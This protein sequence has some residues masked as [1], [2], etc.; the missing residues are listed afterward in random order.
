[1]D[2][3]WLAAR[4]HLAPMVTKVRALL[5]LADELFEGGRSSGASV[6]YAAFE[7]QVAQ[8]TADLE[9]AVHETA[10]RGLD[11]DAPFVRVWG[12]T[13]RRVHRTERTYGTMAG[14]VVVERTLYRERGKR[15]G[16]VLDPVALR[17]GV[18]DGSWL[19]RTARAMSHLLAQG[20]SREASETCREL[21]RLPFSRSSFERVGHAVGAA[22]LARREQIEPQLIEA[23]VIP[24]GAH[25]IS[26]SIDRTTV[27]MEE[28][29]ETRPE[30][31]P[32]E[33][34]RLRE[35]VEALPP[36]AEPLD[37]RT[38]AL[39]R[40]QMRDVERSAKKVER[41]YRMAY[42]AT[43][44]LH[45]A[46]GEALHTIRYGR[47]PPEPGSIEAATHRQVHRLMERLR[48]DV[49]ALRKQ[50]ESLHVVLLADGAPEFW[51]LFAQY[52]NEATL[53]VTPIP[54]IDAWHALEY[55][56]AAARLLESR[57]KAWPGSF[58]RWKGWLLTETGGVERV[59]GA[60]RRAGLHNA[61]DASGARPVG[62]AI[63]YLEDRVARMHYASARATGLP[64]GSGAVEAT[65]KSLV[66]LRMKRPGS[67][68]KQA[69]GDE[70]LQLRALQLSDRW[71]PAITRTLASL[72]RPVHAL[73]R[74]E[75]L[76]SAA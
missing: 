11:I 64:I 7:E 36:S 69:S 23:L 47:M 55:V 20:T 1:M 46:R 29:V 70:V 8:S 59:L 24:E 27:P 35:A 37:R 51:N 9:R 13:Y 50:Y 52:L 28:P 67:R 57:G 49:R 44:T 5:E 26:V 60:L 68:W 54:L 38:K 56:A 33:A 17:A 18:V 63:R 30:P 72:R 12:K 53:G 42:C 75:A 21:M 25:A 58:R 71:A 6:D 4:P 41:N 73:T 65:C 34:A 3:E 76:G 48:D 14:P 15:T 31:T 61:R 62:D 22:Y 19:P 16:P 39:L 45:D 43:I 32:E 40:E 10:L 2:T 66:G 74:E